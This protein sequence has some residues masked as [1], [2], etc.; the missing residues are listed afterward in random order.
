MK[1]VF[2]TCLQHRLEKQGWT[3]EPKTRHQE[4]EKRMRQEQD[5]EKSI[6]ER[7][8]DI[9]EKKTQLSYEVQ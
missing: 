3:H 4:E 1:T 8:Q 2:F 6:P 5:I 7:A 9:K